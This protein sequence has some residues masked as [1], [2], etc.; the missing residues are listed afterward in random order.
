MKIMMLLRTIKSEVSEASVTELV[1]DILEMVEQLYRS[2]GIAI[3][4]SMKDAYC[5]AALECT[6][7]HLAACPHDHDG[8]LQAV[9]RIWRDKLRAME[10]STDWSELVSEE[11][12]GWKDVIEAAL[13][14]P[15]VCEML[16]DIDTRRAAINEVG[17]YLEEA[18]RMMQLFFY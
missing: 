18:W 3:T 7:K 16:M 8:Y 4:E 6:V 11:F 9:K 12:L 2:D 15:E 14:N 1:L 10:N 13:W 5:A 17:A